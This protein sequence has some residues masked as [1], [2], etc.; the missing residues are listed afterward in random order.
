MIA[1]ARTRAGLAALALAVGC[2]TAQ[3]D[4]RSDRTDRERGRDDPAIWIVEF[5]ND[6]FAD[7]DRYY[8][9]GVRLSRVGEARRPPDW[10]AEVA[11]RFP[12]IDEADALPYRFSI[13]HNLYTPSSIEA[14]TPPP[15]D[16]PYA[17]WLNLQFATGTLSERGADRVHVG[18]GLVGPLVAGEEIQTTIHELVG[19]P[20]P[21]G[22]DEQLRNEPT[23]QIGYDRFRRFLTSGGARGGGL[24]GTWLAGMA[25]GNA[26]THVAAGAFLRLGYNLPRGYG[27]PRITPAVS[28][29]GYFKPS[30]R[31]SWY[32][33]AGVEG[34]R[35]LRDMFIE[36]N[37]FGGVDGARHEP[38]VG[39]VFGGFVF[40][41]GPFR[42][43]YTHVWR[44]REFEGQPVDQRYGAL[45]FSL[46]W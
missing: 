22:W 40:T 17:A 11:R 38:Y 21:V 34:R 19:A 43:A 14:P 42:T 5:E 31:T 45:S 9:N 25:L 12:G 35:V 15:D 24:D 4:K 23:L 10:L 32:F 1:G 26:H 41:R 8:T 30:E 16:R 3:A 20:E 2:C 36:G 28:G 6:L 13:S 27:P 29:A 44:S 7:Q 33:Y 46:W 37:T 18:L 39:E